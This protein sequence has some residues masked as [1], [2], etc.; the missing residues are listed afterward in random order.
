MFFLVG[1][2]R[3]GTTALSRYLRKHPSIC[4]SLPK[5]PHFLAHAPEQPLGELRETYLHTFFPHRAERH[6]LLG[7]GSV[8]TLYSDLAIQRA[9]ALDPEA[10]FLAMVRNPM[11]LLPSYHQRLLYVLDEDVRDFATAWRLQDPRARG[12]R[13]PRRCRDPRMLQYAEI[14]RLGARIERLFELAGRERCLV[15]VHD[16]FR[17]DT[18]KV[19]E[20]VLAFLGLE[21]DGRTHFPR[22]LESRTF[23]S[24]ALHRLLM[25]PPASLAQAVL[26]AKVEKER[27]RIADPKSIKKKAWIK[28]AR[29]RLLAW[30][31][32]SAPPAP[33]PPALRDELSE[34]LAGDLALLSHLLGRNFAH[35][36]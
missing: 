18:A 13:I 22:R 6:T 12:D 33:L 2:P 15:I 16:D 30:S 28:R 21:H 7:E 20:Q 14:G 1:A 9:L 27:A 25:R 32:V 34:R 24:L 8:S 4:F 23:R 31:S 17:S 10:R 11:E 5:E 26:R 35:W 36:R 19:Y 29:S 3:C